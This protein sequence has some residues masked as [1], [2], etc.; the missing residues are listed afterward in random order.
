M[1]EDSRGRFWITE[2]P[3]LVA[4]LV[5][6]VMSPRHGA[7]STFSGT[8]RTPSGGRDVVGIF[9]EAY[10]EMAEEMLAKIGAE[11]M[12]RFDVG[13]IAMAHR[14]GEVALG[15]VSVVI[16]VGAARRTSA[17][18][19]C[20]YAIERIKAVLPIWKKERFADGSHWVGWAGAAT[21]TL[22]AGKS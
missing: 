12:Q 21:P 3:L 14:I 10:P 2:E 8:V 7:V 11:L 17:L 15:E 1:R 9:Y 20:S 13:K 5:E 19:G 22:E 6:L 4:G 16:A 18:E